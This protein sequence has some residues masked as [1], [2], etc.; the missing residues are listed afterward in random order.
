MTESTYQTWLN[1]DKEWIRTY[2]SCIR[3][4]SITKAVPLT[5]LFAVLVF[6]GMGFLNGGTSKLVSGA[7]KG[8]E[9]GLGICALYL[10][11]LMIVLH[12]AL[13]TWKMEKSVRK[14][15]MD[16]TERELLGTEM[17]A[18]L[19]DGNGVLSYQMIGPKSQGTP[20]RIILTPHYILQ[21]GSS[22]Y[23]V[24]VRLSDIDKVRTRSIR[25][26]A[27]K[28]GKRGARSKNYHFFGFHTIGFYRKDILERGL[29]E[30]VFPDYAMGFFQEDIRDEVA[31]MMRNAGVQIIVPEGEKNDEV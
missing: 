19:D 1:K 8:L 27:V 28:H 15:L 22:P 14:L 6:G 23:A 2:C 17:L 4:I 10:L 9:L 21:E 13:Y 26:M 31:K 11:I 29:E 24:L 7:V 20:A 30:H 12:P 3:R 5:L 25:K 16:E 18:A